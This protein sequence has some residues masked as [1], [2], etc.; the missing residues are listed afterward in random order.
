MSRLPTWALLSVAVPALMIS[1]LALTQTALAETGSEPPIEIEAAESLEW[2]SNLNVYV[3]HG[4]AR[5]RQ[6]SLELRG[7]RIVAYYRDTDDGGTEIWRVNAEGRVIAEDRGHRAE[8]DSGSYDLDRDVFILTGRDLRFVTPKEVVTARDSLEYWQGRGVA[9]ARGDA[10][11]MNERD[12]IEADVLTAELEDGDGGDRAIRLLNAF[13]NVLIT[14]PTDIASGDMGVYNLETDVATL[15]GRVSLTSDENQLNGD[16]AEVDLE[17]GVS[18]LLAGP[19]S[20]DR[21]RALLVPR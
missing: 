10:V 8:G 14:T 1:A 4:E 11:A 7:D 6:G 17:T 13:G 20:G 16:Y 3:A 12:R 18:R 19:S 5:I 2:Q 9:V 15:T 21:V